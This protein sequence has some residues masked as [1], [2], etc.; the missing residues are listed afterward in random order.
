MSK[1]K[2]GTL[3]NKHRKIHDS[4]F[5]MVSNAQGKW[6]ITKRASEEDKKAARKNLL[7]VC[8]QWRQ[9]LFKLNCA[10]QYEHCIPFLISLKKSHHTFYN[11][12]DMVQYILTFLTK[13]T[14]ETH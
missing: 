5:E 7:K 12:K 8:R 4:Y 6:I 13:A 3:V 11:H 14:L 10:I 9:K 1:R 2:Y